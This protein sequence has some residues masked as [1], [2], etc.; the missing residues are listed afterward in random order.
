MGKGLILWVRREIRQLVGDTRGAIRGFAR[1][2]SALVV[3]N[4]LLLPWFAAIVSGRNTN[5]FPA[6]GEIFGL[7]LV[8][9]FFT[10]RREA[11]GIRV[12]RPIIETA[13][14][15][16]LVLVWMLF[17]IGEYSKV[18]VLPTVAFGSIKDVYET[19]VPKLLEMVLVP[20]AIWLTL[21][22]RPR[23]LGLRGGWRDW[24]PSLVP[25][26]V[27]VGLGLFNHRDNPRVW[28]D[29]FVFFFLGAGLPEEFLFR[30]IL[31]TRLEALVKNPVWGLYLAALVFGVS[32]LP[33]NLSNATATN[34]ISA[35]ESA[36][37]FQMSVG[38]ALGYAFQR[39]RNVIPLSVV[40]TLINSAP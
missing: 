14:A 9:W 20:L 2:R 37:T 39:V 40:H 16:A 15:L 23:E 10:R 35:F 12:E 25:I 22:Y 17:R 5:P 29:N 32:H 31:Q 30:G 28:W 4:L 27:L 13:I 8:Y 6:L 18:Y 33:I 21:R 3:A 38:F 1:N 34:W 36:F 19:I 26:V 24:I 7:I 11:E